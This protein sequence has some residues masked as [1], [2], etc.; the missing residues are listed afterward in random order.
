MGNSM[1]DEEALY[2]SL[3]DELDSGNI[4]RGVWAKALAESD[5][6]EAR[7]KARYIVIR[8]KQEEGVTSSSR[9]VSSPPPSSGSQQPQQSD[10]DV[11]VHEASLA[12]FG[13][14][15]TP[16]ALRVYG[17]IIIVVNVIVGIGW[18]VYPLTDLYHLQYEYIGIFPAPMALFIRALI[19]SISAR[20]GYGLTLGQRSAAYGLC[21][22]GGLATSL[23]LLRLA[24]GHSLSFLDFAPILLYW[25]PAAVAFHNW[26]NL[27]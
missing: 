17:T 20:V 18:V 8:A 11:P 6:N 14:Q 16:L 10:P 9:T 7:A 26:R 19:L 3:L 21:V 25:I 2:E 15:R 12:H 27:K 1:G 4:R 23:A 13:D 5:G 22:L 24:D